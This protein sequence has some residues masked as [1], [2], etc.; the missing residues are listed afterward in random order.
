MIIINMTELQKKANSQET[1]LTFT[2]WLSE[3]EFYSMKTISQIRGFP[4]QS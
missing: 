1:H 4:M 2:N 3:F